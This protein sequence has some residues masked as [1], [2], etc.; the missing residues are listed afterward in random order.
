M[1]YTMRVSA[2]LALCL[3]VVAPSP[4]LSFTL[5]DEK[6]AD[7]QMTELEE[8]PSDP[9]LNSVRNLS[10]THVYR[11]TDQ[12]IL[13]YFAWQLFKQVIKAGADLGV[14]GGGGGVQRLSESAKPQNLKGDVQTIFFF[15]YLKVYKLITMGMKFKNL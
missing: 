2:V 11:R 9:N 1:V 10:F 8:E 6:F 7:H 3:C 14:L 13:P 12:H 4:V 5:P 15:S